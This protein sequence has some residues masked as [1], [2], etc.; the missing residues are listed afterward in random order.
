MILFSFSAASAGSGHAAAASEVVI[1]SGATLAQWGYCQRLRWRCEHKYELGQER[2][3]F[4]GDWGARRQSAAGSTHSRCG[5]ANFSPR[6]MPEAGQ[7]FL[8]VTFTHL[9]AAV[10]KAVPALQDLQDLSSLAS[11]TIDEQLTHLPADAS[12]ACAFW[13]AVAD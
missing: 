13:Q 12:Q 8:T 5:E 3:S 11:V 9:A 6:C 1:E 4:S 10:S 7:P 2:T